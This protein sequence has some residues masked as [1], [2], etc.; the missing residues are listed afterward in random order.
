MDRQPYSYSKYQIFNMPNHWGGTE[1][2]QTCTLGAVEQ[3]DVMI[4]ILYEARL[5]MTLLGYSSGNS[6]A[7][8]YTP[9]AQSVPIESSIE[10]IRQYRNTDRDID[11]N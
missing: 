7:T 9:P 4:T 8:L 5:F 11:K 10:K 1:A 2:G 6:I 3:S